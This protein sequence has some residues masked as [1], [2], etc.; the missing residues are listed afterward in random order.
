MAMPLAVLPYFV[1]GQPGTRPPRHAPTLS[2]ERAG[3]DHRA[4]SLPIERRRITF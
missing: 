3:P 2:L 4:A 1:G